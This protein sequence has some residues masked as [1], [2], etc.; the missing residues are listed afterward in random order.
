MA[1][2]SLRPSSSELGRTVRHRNIRKSLSKRVFVTIVKAGFLWRDLTS[3]TQ[4]SRNFIGGS[5]HALVIKAA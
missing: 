2:L 4:R 3:E 5:M 1:F